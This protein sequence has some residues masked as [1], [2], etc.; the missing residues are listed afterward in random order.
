MARRQHT[1]AHVQRATESPTVEKKGGS[2]LLTVI[3][4]L[5]IVLGIVIG[6]YPLWE[7]F[8]TSYEVQGGVREAISNFEGKYPPGE[9]EPEHRTDAP[10]EIPTPSYGQLF[11]ILHVPAWNYMRTPIVAGT[12]PDVLDF[13]YAGWYEN[14]QLP[15]Q[16]GNFAMA[17]HRRSYGNNF[18]LVHELRNSDELVVET[19]DT[20]IIYQVIHKEVVLPS[21]GWV[22][23]PHPEGLD[24]SDNSRLITLT[25]CHPEFG[26]TERYIVFG[27]FSY[28]TLKSEG[29]PEVIR[30]EIVEN[31]TGKE[32]G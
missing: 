1:A 27:E 8:W 26:N 14:T 6:G 21:A 24:V 3:M 17:G 13:G 19:E 10:P 18:R 9:G 5:L 15:G 25:T 20:Y 28:W 23:S 30:K 11:G 16:V 12:G 22:L 29:K 31:P 4:E 2:K 7:L 32:E